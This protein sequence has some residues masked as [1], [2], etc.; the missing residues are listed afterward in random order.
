MGCLNGSI[1][2]C[3]RCG[4]SEAPADQRTADVPASEVGC[5]WCCAFVSALGY[6]SRHCS[7]SQM[8]AAATQMLT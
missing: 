3:G 2:N 4:V 1:L 8:K 5:S 7:A 6:I